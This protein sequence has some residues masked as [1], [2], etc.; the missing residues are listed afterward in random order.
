MVKKKN[1]L[2]D[3]PEEITEDGVK[4]YGE[5][6]Y[7]NQIAVM[8]HYLHNK[9]EKISDEEKREIILAIREFLSRKISKQEL[10]EEL[11]D[12]Q[13]WTVAESPMQYGFFD[14][15]FNVPFPSPK[16][17]KFTFIDLFAGIGGFRIAMQNFGGK[18]V[19]SSEYNAQAQKTYLENYGEMP[20]GD[21]TKKSTKQYIP[22]VFDVLCA[23]FPCQAFS[24]AG[25]RKG[26][27]DTR[28]TLFFD[29]AE[30]LKQHKPKVAFLENVKNL[31][32]HDKGK[33]FAVIMAT[34]EE[35]GYKVYHKVL[36]AMEYANV[37]QNR[38]RIIIVAFDPNQVQDYE[39]FNFPEQILQL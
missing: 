36:N 12:D 30:I 15:F 10:H 28:G 3:F 39:N 23:G 29:V 19:Y 14:D 21:I 34:L 7:E 35:L 2:V 24:I 33:T 8:C 11:T 31:T 37:P 6:S 16:T 38:E 9:K 27:E 4:V 20:F 25:Y 32:T 22:K 17:P 1:S 13:I 26:F 5:T 18:C